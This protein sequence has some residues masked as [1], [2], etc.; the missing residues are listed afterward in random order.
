[1][2]SETRDGALAPSPEV[3]MPL[4]MTVLEEI[5]GSRVE[6]DAIVS[7]AEGLV[8][9]LAAR[10]FRFESSPDIGPL[11]RMRCLDRSDLTFLVLDPALLVPDYR[12]AFGSET[13]SALGL[14]EQDQALGAGFFVRSQRALR[15]CA[16]WSIAGGECPS[17]EILRQEAS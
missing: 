5:L 15:T 17:S 10:S 2:P 9:L 16:D 14:G 1:M 3:K 7:F 12:P 4:E 11:L 8:G 13:L 6:Q